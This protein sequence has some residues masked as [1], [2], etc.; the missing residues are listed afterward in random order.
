MKKLFALLLALAMILSLA[1]CGAD[2]PAEETPEGDDAVV[3]TAPEDQTPVEPEPE[4]IVESDAAAYLWEIP[5]GATDAEIMNLCTRNYKIIQSF[6]PLYTEAS[7]E[8]Y[9]DVYKMQFQRNQ[10]VASA[11]AAIEAQSQLQQTLTVADGVWFLW[12]DSAGPV[13]DGESYTEEEFDAA[14]QDAYGFKPFIIK[15]LLDDPTTA[16]G[17]IIMISGGAMTQRSNPAEGY[18]AAEIFRE[19]GYNTFLLQRRVAPYTPINIYMDMQRAVRMVRYTAQQEGWGGQ[20]MI[21]AC[22]FSGGGATIL[23]AVRN[24]YGDM[25]PT[26]YDTDYTP[27]AIDAVNS[28]LDVAMIL[29]GSYNEDGTD[30]YVGDNPNLPAFYICHG[31]EDPI[32][33]VTNA[34]ELYDLVNGTV[35]AEL[36]LVDGAKHG[37]GPGHSATAAEGC[38]LW[39][40]QADTFMQ[41]NKGHS[42]N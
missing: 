12:G 11:W 24:C 34:Q 28:D 41:A 32:I 5:E 4:V 30:S 19:M 15:Y 3:D 10:D 23:G 26:V 18:P 36:Y 13:V 38:K 16:K 21:A 40:A 14:K 7:Y 27:D 22:G 35:P 37:F 9:M 17:N 1:A 42:G 33:P 8:A 2:A 6:E 20:D 29:Y 31:M 39:P 25:S